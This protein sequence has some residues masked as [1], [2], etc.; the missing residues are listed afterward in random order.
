MPESG[1]KRPADETKK[2]KEETSREDTS[3][4]REEPTGSTEDDEE[5]TTRK[6]VGEEGRSKSIGSRVRDAQGILTHITP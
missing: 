6:E 1:M 5:D 2:R 4:T 3:Q